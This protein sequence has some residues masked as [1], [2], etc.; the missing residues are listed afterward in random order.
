M[1]RIPNIQY[2]TS[3]SRNATSID[4][5]CVPTPT[6]LPSKSVP[7]LASTTCMNACACLR[8]SRNLLPNP[9][10]EWASGTR[11][12]TSKSSI[13][14]NLVPASH[15]ELLGLH[16]APS[17]VCGHGPLTCPTPRF[18]SIVVN[19]YDATWAAAMVSAEKNV[20]LPTL[21]LPT[22]PTSIL[23]PRQVQCRY[24]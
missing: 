6:G 20:D 11:P 8:S 21:G 10:P 5:S 13:G 4:G 16:A 19:G 14:T 7:P 2:D 1:P 22:M 24:T 17:L 9:F 15:S 23:L 12:A 18:A 3:L